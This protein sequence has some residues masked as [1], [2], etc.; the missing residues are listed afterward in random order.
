MGRIAHDF[1]NLLTVIRMSLLAVGDLA[2]PDDVRDA[3]R[4]ASDSTDR[5][6]RLTHDLLAFARKQTRP[7]ERCSSRSSPPRRLAAAPVSASPSR[8]GS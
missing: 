5:A 7:G 6:A 2:M 4:D 3:I 8:T 1:N